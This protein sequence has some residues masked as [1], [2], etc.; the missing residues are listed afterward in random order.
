[1]WLCLS[2]DNELRPNGLLFLWSIFVKFY[3]F[4]HLRGTSTNLLESARHD[5]KILSRGNFSVTN[6]YS[7]TTPL[8]RRRDDGVLRT[9]C[10]FWPMSHGR[11][12]HY[13][14]M[15]NENEGRKANSA[16]ALWWPNLTWLIVSLGK[17]E[18]EEERG[19]WA[20]QPC[21]I[22][23][24]GGGNQTGALT[25]ENYP[26]ERRNFSCMDTVLVGNNNIALT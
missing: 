12:Y 24:E 16:V 1:M 15:P 10:A 7:K 5:R 17:T 21:R 4:C 26:R 22:A 9:T 19:E 14:M 23:M 8:P 18:M 11:S 2:S 6:K 25:I 3:Q 20:P 13:L